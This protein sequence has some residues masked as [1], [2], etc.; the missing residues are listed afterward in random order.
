MNSTGVSMRNI[1]ERI[2][3]AYYGCS[4]DDNSSIFGRPLSAGYDFHPVRN[5]LIIEYG[6]NASTDYYVLPWLKS[7]LPF[8]ITLLDISHQ[9]YK[10]WREPIPEDT[11]VVIV[12]YITKEALE[13]LEKY[14][15]RLRGVAFFFDDDF[16]SMFDDKSIPGEYRKKIRKLFYKHRNILSRICSEIWVSSPH[17]AKK[18][19]NDSPRLIPAVYEENMGDHHNAIRIFYHGTKIHR[20]EIEWLQPIIKHIQTTRDDT[21][22]EII[23]DHWVNRLFRDIPRTTILHPMSWCNYLEY[24]RAQQLD[25][26]LVPL[27]DNSIN[28]ARSHTKFYDILR[29]GAVGIYSDKQ[30]YKSIVKDWET[31]ILAD[32]HPESWIET[33]DMLADDRRKL[34]SLKLKGS[35][36]QGFE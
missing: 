13:H 27:S 6:R 5:V 34:E 1:F 20:P 32:H 15:S 14:R 33:I 10:N 29:S 17:L 36:I 28:E 25:I 7:R 12:R 24:C 19:A 26:G 11:F 9:E 2:S 4:P 22:F 21:Q 35:R 23:G 31:G 16:I 30:P 18:Y 3:R 8:P